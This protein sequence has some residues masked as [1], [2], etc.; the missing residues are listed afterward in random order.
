VWRLSP[1]RKFNA[2]VV[3][4]TLL[5]AAG[6]EGA[7]AFLTAIRLQ[8]GSSLWEEN[9]PAAPVKGGLASDHQGRILISLSDGRIS[10][11]GPSR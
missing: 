3:A 5:L 7:Q 11:Y 10:C 9:L 4:P 1:A 8:D 6:Q 2:F